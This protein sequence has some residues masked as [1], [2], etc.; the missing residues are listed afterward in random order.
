MESTVQAWP[1]TKR[2]VWRI[3]GEESVSEE[4]EMVLEEPLSLYINGQQVAVLMRLPGLE[5]ELAAGF[6]LSEGLVSD[7]ASVLTIQHCGR[8]LPDDN[9][10]DGAG[11]VESR[12]RVEM[13]VDPRAL[14]PDARM[15]VVRLIRAGC[16][17]VDV[18]RTC[19]PLE[20]LENDIHV[21][22][23]TVLDLPKV[24][25][26]A[27]AVHQHAGGVHAAAL[28]DSR[29]ELIILCE[30]VGRHNAVDKGFGH[31]LLRGISLQDKM[32]LCSGRLSYEMVSKAIRM[33]LPILASVSAPTA[34]A[35]Q[36]ADRFNLTVVGY[37][38]G[39]RMTIYTHP[40]RILSQ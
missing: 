25:H 8:A 2:Q 33:R 29:G 21:L 1:T 24:M 37:L 39:G 15:D 36:L 13:R 38:R 14:N 35:V 31:C 4:I 23:S 20:A 26:A 3:S 17:A 19:L 34:L 28:Y 12:N 11:S 30:D 10:S 6:A 27:Q 16:G 18:D 22:P 9:A 40:Q 7:F 5:K 32:L